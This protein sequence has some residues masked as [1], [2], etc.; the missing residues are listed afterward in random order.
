MS[1]DLFMD[2]DDGTHEP[3]EDDAFEGDPS[4]VRLL[5]D[6]VAQDIYQVILRASTSLETYVVD[7]LRAGA[8][9][10]PNKLVRLDYK[11]GF[12]TIFPQYTGYRE[13]LY[14]QKYRKL[15]EILLPFDTSIKPPQSH[16]DVIEILKL[17]PPAFQ[18]D[19]R[20]GLGFVREMWPI[21]HAIE[22]MPGVQRL[23]IS[24]AGTEL[25]SGTYHF[26]DREFDDLAYGIKQITRK[27]QQDSLRERGRLAHNYILSKLDPV[28]YPL[29]E[30]PYEAGMIFKLL[31]GS[32]AGETKLRGKQDRQ[33]LLSA[34]NA[35][36]MAIAKRDPHEFVQ[37]QKDIE[38]VS[39]D[40]LI[41]SFE[42]RLRYNANETEWQ[43][44]LEINP[45]ILTML[46]GQ[47]IVKLQGGAH[48]GGQSIVGGGGKIADFLLKNTR[49]HN[50]ALVELKR[51][52]TPLFGKEYRAHVFSPSAEIAG[53]IVQVL[54]QRLK[55]VTS[56]P[57][58]KHT[59]RIY[60]LEA[61][62]VECVIVAGRTPT[63]PHKAASF[64]LIRNQIKDVRI[65]TFDELLERLMILRELLSGERYVSE[66]PDEEDEGG[67]DQMEDSTPPG[68]P[69]DDFEQ[70]LG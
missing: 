50:A 44:L 52:K 26:N 13:T 2:F 32:K 19:P 64:E 3:Y 31:G 21:L 11:S 5:V 53:S 36:A 7:N 56:I 4:G 49:T 14:Q 15:V 43:K 62:A 1:D 61:Y 42:Q 12:I 65:I 16:D 18:T 37:L 59:N 63:D 35:N 54:D 28:K 30:Q 45:F 68:V 48:V 6:K 51:P 24:G 8:E 67:H 27:Y 46:F 33:A 47:P 66:L 9:V 10:T 60:D 57:S 22:Q 55:F 25:K 23:K 40:V 20:Y 34:V 70:M 39:L 38:V 41:A 17:L 69:A 58:I 29:K